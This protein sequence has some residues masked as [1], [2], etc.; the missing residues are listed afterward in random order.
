VNYLT[1]EKKQANEII[2]VEIIVIEN[3][4]QDYSKYHTCDYVITN[5]LEHIFD[6]LH[7]DDIH[8]HQQ[9]IKI[10]KDINSF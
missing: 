3:A 9:L 2:I 7:I 10:H 5:E 4:F 1:A 6:E 8:N